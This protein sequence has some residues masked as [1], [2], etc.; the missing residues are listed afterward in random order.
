MYKSKSKSKSKL[1]H[2]LDLLKLSKLPPQFKGTPP[3]FKEFAK[4][5]GII[6]IFGAGIFVFNH[7][8]TDT[9]SSSPEEE[10]DLEKTAMRM[11]EFQ[12]IIVTKTFQQLTEDEIEQFA[13]IVTEVLLFNQTENQTLDQS[14][15]DLRSYK[16]ETPKKITPDIAT[17]DIPYKSW[18]IDILLDMVDLTSESENLTD[19]GSLIFSSAISYHAGKEYAKEFKLDKTYDNEADAMR[20]F[21]WNYNLTKTSSLGI[22]KILTDNHEHGGA[23]NLHVKDLDVTNIEKYYIGVKY[24]YSN[25]TKIKDNITLFTE[26]FDP[27]DQKATFMDMIN[28]YIGRDYDKS[29]KSDRAA[30]DHAK[31]AREEHSEENEGDYLIINPN[32]ITLQSIER[33]FEIYNG[34]N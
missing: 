11:E 13:D 6:I 26:Y 14:D 25:E 28:N 16:N 33:A 27:E 24:V 29:F 31:S 8:Q 7:F 12:K 9:T 34:N 18:M 15:E 1:K 17:S 23:A 22:S 2:L 21:T 5:L 10:I 4:F 19:I 32:E 3:N 30:F 20:H